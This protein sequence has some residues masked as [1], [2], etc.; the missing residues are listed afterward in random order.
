MLQFFKREHQRK[1]LQLAVTEIVCDFE[2]VFK[3]A[4]ETDFTQVRLWGCYFHF[5]KA[6]L[7]K[8]KDLGLFIH[9]G[10]DPLLKGFLRESFAIGYLPVFYVR[11]KLYQLTQ[12]TNARFL[13]NAYPRLVFFTS[14]FPTHMAH[15]FPPN[16]YN[17]Y[18][19]PP[20]LHTINACGGYNNKFNVRVGKRVKPNFWIFFGNSARRRKNGKSQL[21][22]VQTRI[23]QSSPKKKM[24]RLERSNFEFIKPIRNEKFEYR[25]LLDKYRSC[26]PE[27]I[28]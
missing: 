14:V 27:Y 23:P 10:D 16:V 19:C 25:P 22:A 18:A 4:I 8:M 21:F 20:T 2:L 13:K 28:A 1:K 5:T 3:S 15:H 24:A 6:L 11:Q 12:S 17:V 26:L 9:Y 7:K